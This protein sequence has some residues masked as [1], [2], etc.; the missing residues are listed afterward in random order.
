[1]PKVLVLYHFFHPDDVVSAQHYAGLALGLRDRG[2]DVTVMP[3]NR[4]CREESA[5]YPRKESWQGITVRR[6]WRPR[7]SQASSVGRILNA[8]CMLT[9]WSLAPVTR[10]FDVLVIG[11]EPVFSVLV[12]LPWRLF[13]PRTRIF[14]WCFD[15]YPEA[16]VADGML[17]ENAVTT[18]AL[19][20]ALRAAYR[21]CHLIGSL[22]PCMT[23]RL[24]T[25]QSKAAM[26]FLPPWALV[27]PPDVVPRDPDERTAVFGDA[28]L[29]LMSS[30]S[31]GKAHSF[32]SFLALARRLRGHRDVR[33]AFSVRGHRAEELRQA[34]TSQDTNVAF[35]RF[36]SQDR[37]ERRLG[38]AD[39]HMVSLRPS[40]VGTVVPSKFQGAIATG[41]PVLY[42]GPPD[43]S[44]AIW[45]AEH[46]L[47]WVLTP[48]NVGDVA[49]EIASWKDDDA[50][51]R[52]TEERCFRTYGAL[53]SKAATL[54]RLDRELKS[55]LPTSAS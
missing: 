38:A 9:A 46:G 23:R 19:K 18:R 14:H 20:R 55:C 50:S 34:V 48:D 40:F 6:I 17:S 22:G 41:R 16:A 36:A 45:I 3:G 8:A 28:K 37:L 1:M 44:I 42:A 7:L 52:A 33:F 27:E 26:V 53:F 5:R 2:W 11:T 29:A 47:G 31:F 21:S 10:P 35:V 4:G 43:S 32:E 39:I 25:Y 30:G 54:G 13:R 51:R 15:L 12:A 24:E 49:T